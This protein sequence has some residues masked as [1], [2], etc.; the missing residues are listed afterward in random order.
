MK[1]ILE[2]PEELELIL[3]TLQGQHDSLHGYYLVFKGAVLS[4]SEVA[5]N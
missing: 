1:L 2:L 5:F 4:F 3:M